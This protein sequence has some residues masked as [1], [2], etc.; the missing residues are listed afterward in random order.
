MNPKVEVFLR[1]NGF[2]DREIA[3]CKLAT[4]YERQFRHGTDG[5]NRLV[6]I[7]QLVDMLERVE[8]GEI[9]LSRSGEIGTNRF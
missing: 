5:H 2:S 4:I 1:E 9:S 3:E 7:A 6:I 8:N